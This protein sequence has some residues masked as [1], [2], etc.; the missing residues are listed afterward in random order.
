MASM[1]ARFPV[2]VI[3]TAQQWISSNVISVAAFDRS[4]IVTRVNLSCGEELSR[5][6]MWV[7]VGDAVYGNCPCS[8]FSATRDC[9][10]IVSGLL[11]LRAAIERCGIELTDLERQAPRAAMV[12]Q[13]SPK[14]G[15]VLTPFVDDVPSNRFVSPNFELAVRGIVLCLSNHYGHKPDKLFGDMPAFSERLPAY[16]VSQV[17]V[18]GRPMRER[19]V[20]LPQAFANSF[21]GDHW[22]WGGYNLLGH[23]KTGLQYL[24]SDGAITDSISLFHQ[25]ARYRAVPK[26][27][28]PIKMPNSALRAPLV[29]GE[30]DSNTEDLFELERAIFG[31]L[32]RALVAKIPVYVTLERSSKV[33]RQAM[34]IETIGQVEP[35]S[36]AWNFSMR[37]SQIDSNTGFGCLRLENFGGSLVPKAVFP[38]AALSSGHIDFHEFDSHFKEIAAAADSYF[39][40]PRFTDGIDIDGHLR[41]AAVANVL[42]KLARTTSICYRPPNPHRYLDSQSAPPCIV[43][44]PDGAFRFASRV[45]SRV[46]SDQSYYTWDL[47]HAIGFFQGLLQ[48]GIGAI[49]EGDCKEWA[50]SRG[51]KR[52]RDLTVLR[53]Q[54]IGALVF[55]EMVT[56][57]SEFPTPSK[58]DVD[59]RLKDVMGKIA[60]VLAGVTEPLPLTDVCSSRMVT[61]LK[62]LLENLFSYT[63]EETV[64]LPREIVTFRD[65]W[66]ETALVV[67][68][69]VRGTL[70]KRGPALF[71]LQRVSA[72]A[73]FELATARDLAVTR[74]L[75]GTGRVFDGTTVCRAGFESSHQALE[76]FAPLRSRGFRVFKDGVE[77]D[78]MDPKDLRTQIQLVDDAPSDQ[79]P[80][81]QIAGDQIAEGQALDWFEL[82][83]HLFFKGSQLSP[84]QAA[85]FASERVIESGGKWYQLS[86]EDVPEVDHLLN[87][88][89]ALSSPARGRRKSGEGVLVRH[90][91]L[92]LL[93]LRSKGVEVSGFER[94]QSVCRFYDDLG[95]ERDSMALP[96]SLA[97][98]MKPYQKT[99]TQWIHD[100]YRLRLGGILADDMGLGKTLQTLAFLRHIA[101]LD[102]GVK[103]LVIVPTSLTYTWLNEAEKFT[104]DLRIAVFDSK[105]QT[106]AIDFLDAPD[107][108][109]LVVTYG[110]FMEH[111][112]FF[113]SRMWDA[114]VFDEAQSLKNIGAQRS[115]MARE[116]KSHF[117]LAL[118]GTPLENHFGEFFALL[119]LVVPGCLGDLASFRTRFVTPETVCPKDIAYLKL[120]TKPLWLRRVKAH[121]LKELPDRIET[122]VKVPFENS[123]SRLYRDAALSWNIR[124]QESLNLKGVLHSQLMMLTALLRLRQICSDPSCI[125][126]IDYPKVPPKIDV[127]LEALG[128]VI[129][130]GQSALVFT[131]FLGTYRRIE[132]ELK[133]AGLPQFGIQGSLSRTEREK[134]L[135]GFNHHPGGAVMLMTLKTGGVGLNLTKAS[136]VFHIEP[137]WNPAVEHQA[138][139]RA[140]RIG[141]TRSVQVYRY[142]MEGSIEEKIETLKQRKA[143]RFD[144][145]FS[146]SETPVTSAGGNALTRDDFEHL[147]N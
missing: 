38:T 21:H 101:E 49:A 74:A 146:T 131:Q 132:M 73:R 44:E 3:E 87:F 18:Y 115:Q 144:S 70:I 72:F 106:G 102:K 140:H 75:L 14:I 39:S 133:K 34:R 8:R 77:L 19:G 113:I 88:W 25:A 82:K 95:T 136:Y 139:D 117:R 36:I 11:F 7:V 37:D 54:G 9:T 69:L 46:E 80:S 45:D 78:R 62:S 85:R 68:R 17:R 126:G 60:A 27:L 105:N 58:S 122:T 47:S 145:L 71:K 66:F 10:H 2:E 100:L 124:V 84:Q 97:D 118:T 142:I 67:E 23:T 15:P 40:M 135:Y 138:T 32:Q 120:K 13:T 94:W 26:E 4:S 96:K 108:T 20:E 99:G 127:I 125:E 65:R 31:V 91:V 98:V 64:F 111:A 116:L 143:S 22:H 121:I 33:P 6:T 29:S 104:P 129:E 86:I 103:T 35:Q 1:F 141:Q 114:V 43:I 76:A 30:T 24:F 83:P 137:W 61:N 107:S 48:R 92:E 52:D 63:M 12:I 51:D 57:R 56:F 128:E 112:P 119:D 90:H 81:G 59:R 16:D 79:V 89:A 50:A 42:A 93:A 109:I 55:L 5:N 130:S 41:M 110:L 147:L 53:H 134:Q 123:Q 28:I